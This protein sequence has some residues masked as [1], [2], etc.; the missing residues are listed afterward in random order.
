MEKKT[1]V[2]TCLGPIEVRTKF[3]L[4]WWLAV[5]TLGLIR[6]GLHIGVAVGDAIGRGRLHTLVDNEMEHGREFDDHI[7][8]L[9]ASPVIRLSSSK[10]SASMARQYHDQ[11]VEEIELLG[12]DWQ[13][14]GYT[15]VNS[16]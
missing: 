6:R 15:V 16:L 5:F 3:K 13:T 7:R 4:N 11:A 10:A 14:R 12:A 1:V 9:A 8:E 2:D